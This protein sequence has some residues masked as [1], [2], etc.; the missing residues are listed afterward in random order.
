MGRVGR[1]RRCVHKADG[2]FKVAMAD[3]V[4][5]GAAYRAPQLGTCLL[6]ATAFV[7][8]VTH[9]R[10]SPLF[11]LRGVCV[12]RDMENG[13]R[14]LATVDPHRKFVLGT[15]KLLGSSL[16]WAPEAY[17]RDREVVLAAVTQ[18][19]LALEWAAEPCV[20]DHEIVLA[21]VKQAGCALQWAAGACRQ[22]REIVM[23]AVAQ[24]GQALRWAAACCQCDREIV[25]L[26][27][28]EDGFAL[29]W[30]AD[31]WKGNHDIVLG[32]VRKNGS[33]LQFAAK[34]CTFDPE[35]VLTAVNQN[36]IAIEWASDDLLEDGS[37][38]PDAKRSCFILKIT[39]MSGRYAVIASLEDNYESMEEV[40]ASCRHKLGLVKQ[41]SERLVNGDEIVM[42]RAHVC[43]WPKIR[44]CGEVTEYQL[45]RSES[46]AA[47]SLK[48]SAR[49]PMLLKRCVQVGRVF[50]GSPSWQA[51][52]A[53]LTLSYE[54]QTATESESLNQAAI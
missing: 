30:A 28:N 4:F 15:M 11:G 17:K 6:R 8:F 9:V 16:Q 7:A 46:T 50:E 27:V 33:S 25:A 42:P 49:V 40:L 23:A 12:G 21:A 52:H 39:L 29:R 3:L 37:F 5:V 47:V 26:A 18:N 38:A 43:N 45:A 10:L 22:D 13:Q 31:M 34:T 19:G 44:P 35:I 2:C 24:D 14:M 1:G 41:G 54:L 36:A 48:P 51:Q 20:S 32:A 53:V